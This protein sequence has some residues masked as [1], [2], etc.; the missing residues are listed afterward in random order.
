MGSISYTGNSN[1]VFIGGLAGW[2]NGIINKT[3][4]TTSIASSGSNAFKGG[5][6]GINNNGNV[7]NSFWDTG[8]SGRSNAFGS[9]G[10]SSSS[11]H[12]LAGC[13]GGNCNSSAVDLT[14]P[15]TFTTAG[16]NVGFTWGIIPGQSYPYLLSFYPD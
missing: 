1:T 4:S 12:V 6:V 11:N 8:V 7:Q 3:Y 2:N 15:T 5:L 13:F 10:S 9:T 14:L 16:F